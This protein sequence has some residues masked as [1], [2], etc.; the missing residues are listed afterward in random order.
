[1]KIIDINHYYP[2][3]NIDY[4]GIPLIEAWPPLYE[5]QLHSAMT[6]IPR[7][8]PEERQH[9][10]ELRLQYIGRL[11]DLFFPTPDQLM[12]GVH[13]W[14]SICKTYVSNAR[15]RTDSAAVFYAMC[16][17]F[18]KDKALRRDFTELSDMPN[19]ITVVGTPGCGKTQVGRR[20]LR[21]LCS[22]SLLRHPHHDFL[23]QRLF[24]WT[25]AGTTKTE[26]ALAE[27]VYEELYATVLATGAQRARVRG[28]AR[29]LGFECAAM[30]RMLNLGVLVLD[31][32]QHW[33][34]KKT[35]VDQDAVE[36]LTTLVNEIGCTVMLIGTWEALPILKSK[37]RGARR[38]TSI[39]TTQI[40][41]IPPGE[42][43]EA[44]MTVLFK[45]QFTTHVV[46]CND[47]LS[48]AFWRCTQGVPDFA[49][50]L[51]AFAQC[52][53]IATESETIDV[54]LV[55]AC[56]AKHLDYIQ[57]AIRQMRDGHRED[58]PT[59]WD[60]EPDDIDLYTRRILAEYQLA[61]KFEAAKRAARSAASDAA[62][63]GASKAM[64]ELGMASQEQAENFANHAAKQDP[65]A[66]A[67]EIVA[68]AI[69]AAKQPR[70]RPTSSLKR[71]AA[72]AEQFAALPVLDIRR[73]VYEA[74]ETNRSVESDMKKLGHLLD[75]DNWVVQ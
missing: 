40:K 53:A 24:L 67:A 74:N 19:L 30:A 63:E 13:L 16:D 22:D 69:K 48:S 39:G 62:A 70:L 58:S 57:P 35:G 60:A 37:L 52:E 7:C 17:S 49:V 46:P 18:S 8:T 45:L 4:Q 20:M 6:S 25:E 41:K 64:Q 28:S 43:W 59:I 56:A 14:N 21:R 5:S 36:F 27:V 38:A 32:I 55:E 54:A 51:M 1:M 44:F 42:I 65:E 2:A 10:P 9:P 33:L 12:L 66:T 26:K 3:H 29:R 73:L 61:A 75:I 72:I 47:N 68:K 50:R 23:F 15:R 31:E 34:R 71:K 11:F